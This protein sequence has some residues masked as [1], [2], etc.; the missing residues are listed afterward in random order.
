MQTIAK[1][2]GAGRLE[3]MYSLEHPCHSILRI[4][5]AKPVSGWTTYG[6]CLKVEP[7]EFSQNLYCTLTDINSYLTMVVSSKHHS[8]SY[9]ILKSNV[10]F[11]I[12]FAYYSYDTH[13]TILTCTAP[14]ASSLVELTQSFDLQK[15]PQSFPTTICSG[16][17]SYNK[18]T[19][20]SVALAMVL[21]RMY[22]PQLT[23]LVDTFD[24][25][26][27]Q[28][29]HLVY[30]EGSWGILIQTNVSY[31]TRRTKMGCTSIYLC[32]SSIK[33]VNQYIPRE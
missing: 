5:G 7:N 23:N 17:E 31:H 9:Q 26:A 8:Y 11:K 10:Y 30:G 6:W 2:R 32:H 13:T 27:R 22:L 24:D 20:P 29:V 21:G 14:E 18:S 12:S 16:K 4:N 19:V 28:N 33:R 3:G 25:L 1:E 15:T